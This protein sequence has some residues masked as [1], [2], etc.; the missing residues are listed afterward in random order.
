MKAI[1][2]EGMKYVYF[3][4]AEG[5]PPNAILAQSN[6]KADVLRAEWDNLLVNHL[7]SIRLV[8][9]SSSITPSIKSLYFLQWN[10][11]SDLEALDRKVENDTCSD[12]DF[13]NAVVTNLIH[14]ICVKK[15]DWEGEGLVL[16]TADA[17]LN[18]PG[19]EEKKLKL[20]RA[21][22]EP[23]VCPICGSNVHQFVVKIFD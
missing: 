12:A 20:R 10:D 7:D 17:Y 1:E 13:E 3:T 21:Q 4:K 8:L 9:I 23:L 16:H 2:A 6:V 11:S 19:L 18:A 15:R 14:L 5:L 22:G